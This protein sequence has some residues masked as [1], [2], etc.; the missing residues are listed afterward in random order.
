MEVSR[1]DFKILKGKSTRKRPLGGSMS[2]WE[3]NIKMDLKEILVN[4]RDWVD[5]ISAGVIRESL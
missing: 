3:D 2:K 5:S 1:S 4:T